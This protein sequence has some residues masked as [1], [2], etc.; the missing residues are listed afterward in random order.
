MKK[1]A[2]TI[3][4]IALAI[5]SGTAQTAKKPA[6][7]GINVS[8]TE[9]APMIL[10]DGKQIDREILDMIDPEKIA[11]INVI[12]DKD[13]LAKYNAPNG[14]III[15]SKK[16]QEQEELKH[17]SEAKQTRIRGNAPDKEPLVIIDGQICDN[18]TLQKLDPN[19]IDEISVLKDESA[20]RL[21]QAE[22]GVILI[23]TKKAEEKKAKSQ[24]G[25]KK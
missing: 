22:N 2:L 13:Q 11:H 8:K 4:V 15:T 17:S 23:S 1:I 25:P 7:I 9:N 24:A 19:D 12:K 5:L 16:A 18:D 10:V 3:C 20:M 6:Q 21:Y 14:L